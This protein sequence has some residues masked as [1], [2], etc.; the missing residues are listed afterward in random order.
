MEMA[1]LNGILVVDIGSSVIK[2]GFSGEDAPRS[3]FLSIVGRPKDNNKI[4]FG[5]ESKDFYIGDEAS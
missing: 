5:L 4:I 1:D 2:A 3:I